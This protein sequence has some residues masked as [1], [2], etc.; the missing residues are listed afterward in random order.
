M[1]SCRVAR[2]DSLKS[3]P[4]SWPRP[5]ER[6]SMPCSAAALDDERRPMISVDEAVQRITRAFAP[7]TGERI[8]L[9]DALG[10]VL[11]R[12][13]VALFDHPPAPMSAMDGYAVRAA[14]ARVGSELTVIGQAPAGRPLA[15]RLGA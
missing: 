15:G 9:S 5:R 1:G 7:L 14:D 8:V 11:A 10:R 3:P 13:A 6:A 2:P 4:T 12:D